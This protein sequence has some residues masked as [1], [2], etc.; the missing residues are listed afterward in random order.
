MTNDQVQ[1]SNKTCACILTDQKTANG[2]LRLLI[3]R[4]SILTRGIS[5]KKLSA[6]PNLTSGDWVLY[7]IYIFIRSVHI[8]HVMH[9]CSSIYW[10]KLG[11]NMTALN[12]LHYFFS[13]LHHTMVH[14][15]LDVSSSQKILVIPQK[16]RAQS[17]PIHHLWSA[18]SLSFRLESTRKRSRKIAR[19]VET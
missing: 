13:K 4:K 19:R 2:E 10:V 15:E 3:P 14:N 7:L 12:L 9:Y 18:S 17:R 11:K 8:I 1:I 5:E 6:S 16:Q